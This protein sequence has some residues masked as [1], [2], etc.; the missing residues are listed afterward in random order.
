MRT[1]KGI[2]WRMGLY[3]VVAGA[4]LLWTAGVQASTATCTNADDC[5]IGT[6]R[7]ASILLW[8]KV[9]VDTSNGT[10]TVIQLTNAS[11]RRTVD[12]EC[13]YVSGIGHCAGSSDSCTS[14]F[15][16]GIG[17]QCIRWEKRDFR[18]TLT[19]RQP[20]SWKAS[21]GAQFLPCDPASPDAETCTRD[22]NG[23]CHRERGATSYS[24]EPGAKY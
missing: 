10:D 3:G 5:K 11:D 8:P 14:D 1:T 21:E 13:F 7:A 4:V 16:C 20:V 15:Q 19:K 12:V 24:P 6:D 17:G 2:P 22:S 23:S 18:L 9:V